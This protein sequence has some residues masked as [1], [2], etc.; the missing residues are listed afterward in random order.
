M[1]ALTGA[2]AHASQ[3]MPTENSS[4]SAET[5]R[6]ELFLD[7][8]NERAIPSFSQLEKLLMIVAFDAA[9]AERLI[10][11]GES[12][13]V[14][15]ACEPDEGHVLDRLLSDDGAGMQAIRNVFRAMMETHECIRAQA[16][17]LSSSGAAWHIAGVDDST[18]MSG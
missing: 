3:P 5:A 13:K 1:N 18:G 8:G 11:Y 4:A 12:A 17:H 16:V 10:R 2:G 7:I 14:R 6:T 15:Y 9:F